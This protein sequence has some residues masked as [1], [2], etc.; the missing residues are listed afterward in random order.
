MRLIAKSL[1]GTK[2]VYR[3]ELDEDAT[4]SEVKVNNYVIIDFSLFNFIANFFMAL[5]TC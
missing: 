1:D 4:I 2:K 3:L 5:L